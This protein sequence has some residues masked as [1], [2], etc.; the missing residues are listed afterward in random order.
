MS[1]RISNAQACSEESFYSSAASSNQS[2]Q[3]TD[4]ALNEFRK[5]DISA[6]SLSIFATISTLV[7]LLGFPWVSSTGYL[8]QCRSDPQ[9]NNQILCYVNN[10]TLSGN[11][12]P[13]NFGWDHNGDLNS[14][15]NELNGQPIIISTSLWKGC[16]TFHGNTTCD[17][18]SFQ[19]SSDIDASRSFLGLSI[20]FALLFI[21][22][23]Q[24]VSFMPIGRCFNNRLEGDTIS[25][26]QQCRCL[27]TVFP[28]PRLFWHRCR[29]CCHRACTL[30]HART[31]CCFAKYNVSE[32]RIQRMRGGKGVPEL[33]YLQFFGS[34]VLVILIGGS[35]GILGTTFTVNCYPGLTGPPCIIQYSEINWGVGPI[36]GIIALVT[37][38]ANATLISWSCEF[39]SKTC[40][41]RYGHDG[42]TDWLCG[43]CTSKMHDDN[44]VHFNDDLEDGYNSSNGIESNSEFDTGSSRVLQ[45]LSSG[46]VN[47]NKKLSKEKWDDQI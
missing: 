4:G 46:N 30:K 37:W 34:F 25:N 24:I 39:C 32:N 33:Y 22:L 2:Q 47:G 36:F 20:I 12:Y 18:D 1:T 13:D 42:S 35:L 45:K 7:A 10:N 11:F 3:W 14:A 21:L 28:R 40:Y 6:V 23:P 44:N 41:Y 17:T 16:I 27:S 31:G 15:I 26:Y 9:Q 29:L 8:G 38:I 19:P 43:V 5:F